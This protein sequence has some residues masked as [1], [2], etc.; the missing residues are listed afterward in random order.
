MKVI[1]A[2][3]YFCARASPHKR[4][5]RTFVPRGAISST[6]LKHHASMPEAGPFSSQLISFMT[7]Y[8]PATTI[9]MEPCNAIRITLNSDQ[10]IP[11]HEEI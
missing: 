5:I 7:F 10:N 2:R 11:T 6:Q 9:V 8:M 4:A 1:A 3:D